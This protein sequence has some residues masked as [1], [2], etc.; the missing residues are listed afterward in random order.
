MFS[1]AISLYLFFCLLVLS[2]VQTVYY[3]PLLPAN[4]ASRF[5]FGG[6][7][8]GWTDKTA[9]VAVQAVVICI[10][11]AC[12][13]GLPL[14]FQKLPAWMI[15]MPNKD[16][17]LAPERRKETC[18]GI[19]L[20]MYWM[21]DATLIFIIACNQIVIRTNL[22]P[23]WNPG[24]AF[25]VALGCFLVFTLVWTCGWYYQYRRPRERILGE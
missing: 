12:F 25:L 6:Q 14:I 23:Q 19:C 9:L 7:A 21:G 2:A 24:R 1:R 13:F 10:I 15:N 4:V 17:W 18:R 8:V 22:Q 5:D 11:V 20:N 3:Y 16:Y